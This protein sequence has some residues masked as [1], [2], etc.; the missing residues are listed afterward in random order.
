MLDAQSKYLGEVEFVAEFEPQVPS[1]RQASD[2]KPRSLINQKDSDTHRC[3]S[4]VSIASRGLMLAKGAG[5]PASIEVVL[6]TDNVGMDWRPK[7]RFTIGSLRAT[8]SHHK[9]DQASSVT[10]ASST[11][12]AC[13]GAGTVR[14]HNAVDS[15]LASAKEF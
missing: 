5:D 10:M 7:P 3:A 2:R 4:F 11:A 1:G 14:S 8:Q 15:T 12:E 9:C 13:T 6:E